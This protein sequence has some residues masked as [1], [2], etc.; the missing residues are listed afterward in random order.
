MLASRRHKD[1]HRV[2]VLLTATPVLAADGT[3]LSWVGV[4]REPRDRPSRGR[5]GA[6][7]WRRWRA[8]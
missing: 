4:L 7:W 5:A 6:A 3:L 8:C 1:G 2:D